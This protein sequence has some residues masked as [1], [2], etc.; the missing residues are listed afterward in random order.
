MMI[1]PTDKQTM[2]KVLVSSAVAKPSAFLSMRLM[3][4]LQAMNAKI[5]MENV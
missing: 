5:P 2:E 3:P 4:D 1:S